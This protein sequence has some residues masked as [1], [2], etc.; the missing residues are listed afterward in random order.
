M[1]YQRYT[2]EGGKRTKLNPWE[3]RSLYKPQQRV[4]SHIN[5]FLEHPDEPAYDSS[6]C[7]RKSFLTRNP[8]D[9]RPY[10][11]CRKALL[12][13]IIQQLID[14]HDTILP[15]AWNLFQ[16]A[17][18]RDD[19]FE[20]LAEEL[21]AG[22]MFA[23]IEVSLDD[24]VIAVGPYTYIVPDDTQQPFD[25]SEFSIGIKVILSDRG[26][27]RSVLR[28]SGWVYEESGIFWQFYFGSGREAGNG[29]D[30]RDER[31]L[32]ALDEL[33]AGASDSAKRLLEIAKQ[34]MEFLLN[35]DRPVDQV[36]IEQDSSVCFDPL[37]RKKYP[38]S[39]EMCMK[40]AFRNF[41][42]SARNLVPGSHNDDNIVIDVP[43][44]SG[45]VTRRNTVQVR[46]GDSPPGHYTFTF[47]GRTE[48]VIKLQ[49]GLDSV[50]LHKVILS[51]IELG[52]TEI[53]G[54]S[55]RDL[56]PQLEELGLDGEDISGVLE[57]FRHCETLATF[58]NKMYPTRTRP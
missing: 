41:A 38:E 28:L 30:P 4:R 35:I 2:T 12:R 22:R 37:V 45:L 44:H 20:Q 46:P 29:I 53:R 5:S 32:S 31:E 51:T 8:R 11:S 10:I 50:G 55:P 58:V 9:P 49:Y 34:L 15:F 54:K 52:G 6:Y 14:S 17:T 26:G 23:E 18:P 43:Y 48:M 19:D 57:T 47:N 36:D 33:F 3:I 21:E 1:A 40:S 27:N 56:V 39:A 42:G 13:K 16:L 7:S 24:T 25:K